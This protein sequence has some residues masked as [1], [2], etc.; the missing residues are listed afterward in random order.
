MWNSLAPGVVVGAVVDAGVVEETDATSA[1]IAI[2]AD[3]TVTSVGEIATLPEETGLT[4][5][6]AETAVRR[7]DPRREDPHLGGDIPGELSLN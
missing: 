7:G 6:A 2:L 4:E 1:E 5:V 3:G